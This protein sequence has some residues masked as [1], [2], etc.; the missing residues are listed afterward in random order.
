MP[1]F[2]VFSGKLLKSDPEGRPKW[3]PL[4]SLNLPP[5][6]TL[7]Y[8]VPV[9]EKLHPKAVPRPPRVPKSHQNDTKMTPNRHVFGG[10]SDAMRDNL[11]EALD[12][13]QSP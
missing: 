9:G 1:Y 4:A 5:E 13:R 12:T 11:T 7:S 2:C 8:F 3:E 10:G 6:L